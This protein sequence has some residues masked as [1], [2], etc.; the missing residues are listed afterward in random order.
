MGV[1]AAVPG[2]RAMGP[3]RLGVG[4]GPDARRGVRGRRPDG[5][6]L[7]RRTLATAQPRSGATMRPRR[8]PTRRVGPACSTGYAEWPTRSAGGPVR[9]RC[10]TSSTWTATGS[11]RSRT[12]RSRMLPSA[13]PRHHAVVRR[14]RGEP[15]TTTTCSPSA[16]S[17]GPGRCPP[18]VVTSEC[19]PTARSSRSS[20]PSGW[21]GSG[22]RS[23]SR[24]PHYDGGNRHSRS[25][26]MTTAP[27]TDRAA[28]VRA[29][30]TQHLADRGPLMPVLH[31][32]MEELGHVAREDVETIADVL[33][34]SVAEVHG[35]VSFYHDF[36]TGPPAAHT[37]AL[38]RGEACQSVGAEA[39]YDE[40]AGAGGQPRRRRR[41]HRGLL[42]RQLRARAVRH[43]GRSPPRPA[44]GRAARRAHG[45]VALT[46]PTG[47]VFVPG[48][49][50]AVSVGADEVAA[51]F[52]AAGAQVVRNGSR[53]MLWLEPLVEV[54]T[55]AGRVGLPERDRRRRR[56]RA[57]GRRDR[58]RRRRRASL[59]DL[60]AA[61]ELRPRRRRRPGLDRRLRGPRRLGRA[62]PGAV[63]LPRRGRP[64]GHRLRAAR[65]RRRGLPGRHQVED[66]AGD[67]VRPEVRRPAT[68]TRATPG[69]S[70][71][72]C[73]SRATRSRWSR[74]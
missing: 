30:A 62:A 54:E 12:Q 17:G 23:R 19:S 59:A 6:A 9:T 52:E 21:P 27:T 57:R 55:D 46:A 1:P 2:R 64:G 66:R 5:R 3:A 4:P 38:C 7:R 73:S 51:A 13:A 60:A 16:T 40:H 58:H 10:L 18:P 68:S 43:A 67:G 34:L 42:P 61:G 33:N 11:W 47:R 45:G 53:G 74:A 56:R 49:A 36:R 69:R 29:I 71:T 22:S 26:L 28:L 15:R 37:V 63:A 31:D 70:P 65:P 20:G 32:V 48:D 24:Q 72:G 8:S 14:R 44:L 41:G 39:L 50:A 35:V 25:C